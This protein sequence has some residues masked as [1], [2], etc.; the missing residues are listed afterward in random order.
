MARCL[1]PAMSIFLICN[2]RSTAEGTRPREAKQWTSGHTAHQ[3]HSQRARKRSLDLHVPL[4]PIRLS[5]HDKKDDS[6]FWSGW[7]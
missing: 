2:Y 3:R 5:V 4:S 7:N 1:P 6:L